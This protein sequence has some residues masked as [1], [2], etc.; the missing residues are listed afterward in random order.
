MALS[1]FGLQSCLDYDTPSD[2][3]Q[4]NQIVAPP[5]ISKCEAD[6][7][8]YNIEISEKGYKAAYK[9]L[10]RLVGQI[11]SG[12][13]ALRGGK[14]GNPPAEHAYQVLF[15]LGPDNYV[16]YSCVTHTNFPYSNNAELLST[17]HLSKQF[18]G[19]P[20]N[21]FSEC[22]TSIAPV[23]NNGDIDSIPELK[24]ASLLLYNYAA[25]ENVD[26]F[27]PMPYNDFKANREESPFTYND[28]R[29]IY[30]SA[31]DNIDTCVAA[32]KHF[33]TRPQWYKAIVR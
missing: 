1:V 29:T 6:K 24:A 30:Y 3:L 15:S 28:M 32:F 10:I 11:Q 21:G 33:D 23:L 7:I 27:G 5:A 25:I 2:E 22:K 13:Y 14:E 26:L 12:I 18:I 16:Q 20:G 4:Q 9:R 8:N 31:V 19:G 17:Y